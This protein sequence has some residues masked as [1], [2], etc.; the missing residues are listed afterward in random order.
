MDDAS[1]LA[2]VTVHRRYYSGVLWPRDCSI[3]ENFLAGGSHIHLPAMGV[4]PDSVVAVF[5]S[6]AAVRLAV[7]LWLIGRQA[8]TA[9]RIP[10]FHRFAFP[11]WAS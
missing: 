4:E 7:M 3:W 9:G 11:P 2:R 1:S 10:V 6:L 5:V 8:W